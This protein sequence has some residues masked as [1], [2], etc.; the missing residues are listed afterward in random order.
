MP[1][2]RI[3]FVTVIWE[4]DRTGVYV[5]DDYYKMFKIKPNNATWKPAARDARGIRIVCDDG[6]VDVFVDGG[7]DPLV[8]TSEHAA[9]IHRSPEIGFARFH[10]EDVRISDIAVR[11]PPPG[12]H[13]EKER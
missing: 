10:G 9:A 4:K 3:P 8:S 1:I 13:G 2:N 6:R 11:R 12:A 7:A 5:E